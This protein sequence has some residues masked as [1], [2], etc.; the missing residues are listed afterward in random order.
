MA[1]VVL[2]PQTLQVKAT[3]IRLRGDFVNSDQGNVETVSASSALAGRDGPSIPEPVVHPLTDAA[4]KT[5]PMASSYKSKFQK[6]TFEKSKPMFEIEILHSRKFD[7]G[8]EE[9][10]SM[11]PIRIWDHNLCRPLNQKK[12]I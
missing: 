2:C 11:D 8:I 9:R 6:N 4:L 5:N 3:R 12:K 10:G 1:R 7:F